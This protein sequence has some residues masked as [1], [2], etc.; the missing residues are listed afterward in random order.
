MEEKFTGI[1]PLDAQLLAAAGLFTAGFVGAGA[2]AADVLNKA[3]QDARPETRALTQA[4]IAIL[5]RTRVLTGNDALLDASVSREEAAESFDANIRR[6]LRVAR[7]LLV[8]AESAVAAPVAA[9]AES[10]K[11]RIIDVDKDG[12]PIF[13]EPETETA[14][15]KLYALPLVHEEI[16]LIFW[17]LHIAEAVLHGDYP[18]AKDAT[19][20]YKNIRREKISEEAFY[21]FTDRFDAVHG[22][23]RKDDGEGDSNAP[24]R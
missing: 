13:A 11:P 8:Y 24:T 5:G 20:V 18:A 10:P 6:V 19:A 14:S 23:A 4:A 2:H 3:E 12:N 9:P 21:A 17:A 1:K 16:H 15:A 22:E 7:D